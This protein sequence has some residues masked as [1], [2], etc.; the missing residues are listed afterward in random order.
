MVEAILGRDDGDGTGSQSSYDEPQAPG[1]VTASLAE[2]RAL[3]DEINMRVAAQG[4][5]VALN[6][7]ALS[8]IG[9][10]IIVNKADPS[11]LLIAPYLS[12]ALGFEWMN[13]MRQMV[14]IGKYTGT[15][16]WPFLSKMS[17]AGLPSW[18]MSWSRSN[19]TL[20]IQAFTTLPPA[21]AFILPPIL[22]LL[23]SYTAVRRTPLLAVWW[24]DIGVC[25]GLAVL[26]LLFTWARYDRDGPLVVK[27]RLRAQQ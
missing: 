14:L 11:L 18:E 13:H 15:E 22:A 21:A 1:A 2:Y 12:V 6:L 19:P 10:L 25:T 3:R 16:L 9:G 7:T 4:R 20:A 17:G 26:A 24:A 23:L 27:R 5:L 8:A